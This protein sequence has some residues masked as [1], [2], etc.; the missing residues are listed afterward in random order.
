LAAVLPLLLISP[1]AAVGVLD[2][3][4]TEPTT[5][6]DGS[7]LTD[8]ESYRVYVGTSS[9]PCPGS[10]FLEVSSS[11]STPT[12]MEVTYHLSGLNAGETDFVQVT[13]V[14]T[15]GFESDCSNEASGQAKDNPG[16][17]TEGG[18]GGCFIATAAFGSP[19]APQVQ[20]LRDFRDRHLLV[21]S[22]GRV[23]V[24]LYYRMSPPLANIIASSDT[25]RAI[26]HV[27]LLPIL[28]WATLFLWSPPLGLATLLLPI[29]LLL[30]PPLRLLRNLLARRPAPL[31]P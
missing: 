6:N 26:V 15:D 7:Q 25:L 1:V 2:L 4:W 17:T 28:A 12:G 29:G 11:T 27:G 22:P 16:A 23:L 31:S 13:A 20:I 24:R 8:L 3:A 21:Y 30:C 14:D 10:L 5:N 18:G 19:L 9:G